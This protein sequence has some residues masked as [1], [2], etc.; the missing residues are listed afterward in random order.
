M[1]LTRIFDCCD[2]VFADNYATYIYTR[3]MDHASR[4]DVATYEEPHFHDKLERARLQGTE[5]IGMLQATDKLVQQVLTAMSLVAGIWLFSPWIVL[6]LIACLIR[7]LR[8]RSTLHFLS[9]SQVYTAGDGLS[10][11]GGRKPGERERT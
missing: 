7:F 9:Y 5:R 2:A 11:G 3:I 4:L 1:V 10:S 8:E 6:I